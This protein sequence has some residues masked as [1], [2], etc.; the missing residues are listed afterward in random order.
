MTDGVFS[1]CV[2]SQE[3]LMESISKCFDTNSWE[4]L[5]RWHCYVLNGTK[6][7]HKNYYSRLQNES[8]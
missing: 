7:E 1:K 4:S 3:I 5:L 8:H 6:Y 2:I